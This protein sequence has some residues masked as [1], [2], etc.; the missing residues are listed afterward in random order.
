VTSATA[1]RAI[2]ITL[3]V[4]ALIVRSI[5]DPRERGRALGNLLVLREQLESVL[6]ANEVRQ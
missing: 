5:T 4:E 6:V 3:E 2:A 1:A